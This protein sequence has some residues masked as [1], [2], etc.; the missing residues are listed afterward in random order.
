MPALVC[1]VMLGRLARWLRLLGVDT[2]Y[3]RD[4]NDAELRGIAHREGR[5]LVTRDVAL[6]TGS[7]A[8]PH[9]LLAENDLRGQLVHVCR[10]LGIEPGPGCFTRCTRCNGLLAEVS[11]E[12]VADR[13]FPH[14]RATQERVL[15]CGSCA[16]LY[17]EGTH[18]PH[19]REMLE[20]L[21]EMLRG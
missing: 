9:V 3:R 20:S 21:R 15:R 5:I 16:K 12:S 14:V 11:P 18:P 7:G 10:S 4:F 2:L 6:V 8:P 17:W 13:L 19:I 1:D